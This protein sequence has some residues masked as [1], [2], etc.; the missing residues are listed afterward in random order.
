[1][2]ARVNEL[3][4]SCVNATYTPQRLPQFK[5]NPL[6]EAL[7][8]SPTEKETFE[9]L[10]L[11]PQFDPEQRS[12]TAQERLQ[13]LLTLQNF[14]FPLSKHLELAFSLDALLRN[15]YVG[16]MPMTPEHIQRFQGNYAKQKDGAVFRQ[17]ADT[18][19][20]QLSTLLIG[21]S[22]MGKT[23]T[24]RRWLAQ[25]PQVIY[26]P[27]FNIYQIT[28][29]HVEMPSDGSS[30]KGL[31]HAILKQIDQLIPGANYYSTY[32]LKG[33][34]GADALM[35][36]VARVLNA[37]FVGCLIADE[38]QNLANA[39]KGGQTV[40]TELVSACN[41]LGVPI[42]F[43]GTNKAAKVFSL[44]F[45]QSRRASG[46]GLQPW[47]RMSAH[48]AP[49]EADEWG[50]FVTAM[51]KYQWVRKPVTISDHLIDTLYQ[52]SQGIIDVAIKL[53]ASCQARAMLDGSETVNAELIANVY[54]T[55]MQLLHP[56]IEALRDHDIERLGQ[57]EDVAPMGLAGVL[58]GIDRKLRVKHSKTYAVRPTDPTFVTRLASSLVSAGID[59]DE[60][61]GAA[62]EVVASGKAQN[63]LSGT[64]A[65]LALISAP[66]SAPRPNGHLSKTADERPAAASDPK[67]YRQAIDLAK[68]K[69]TTVYQ[70]LKAIGAARPLETLLPLH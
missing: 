21:P 14:M 31:A 66:R 8:R 33:R 12:W 45:R 2:N 7:P 46:H 23:S 29:L 11:E 37:H 18:R 68:E 16:R 24:V 6:I 4:P 27:N 3:S 61:M 59:E 38:V 40:M 32:A 42:L 30:I 25:I 43:I 64:K 65:A 17:S 5:G 69:G 52:Y 34:V 15:G 22:G 10:S 54:Q 44:D 1:M 58:E 51:W 9:L 26:H 70:Q 55:E 56:M 35:R 20:S 48:P 19:T 49:G 39:T 60:A 13:M 28:Y 67:D 41:D 53:F 62:K 50:E 36:G 47:D 57:F 63:L